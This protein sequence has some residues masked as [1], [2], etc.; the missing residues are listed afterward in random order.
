MPELPEPP[1]GFRRLT[2]WK[3]YGMKYRLFLGAAFA[4][5]LSVCALVVQAQEPAGKSE[6][7]PAPAEVPWSQGVD[8]LACRLIVAKDALLNEPLVVVFEIKNV[9]GRKRFVVNPAKAM[10]TDR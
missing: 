10:A 9:S 1:E 2:A 4:A 7:R 5:V 8:G 3:E 6:T